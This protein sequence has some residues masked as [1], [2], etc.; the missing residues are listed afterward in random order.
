MTPSTSIPIPEF[1]R[2]VT[3][4][5]SR[6]HRHL[7]Y[8]APKVP[9]YRFAARASLAA[10]TIDEFPVALGDFPIVFSRGEH[11]L[12]FAMVGDP[13]VSHNQ[14]VDEDGTW[15][16]GT[17][18]PAVIRR[19]PFLLAKLDPESDEA[20]LCFDGDCAW[21]AGKDE[22]NLF[23]SEDGPTETTQTI[24]DFCRSFEAAVRRTRA[25]MDELREFE[26]LVD[27]RVSG[28]EARG[29]GR[30]PTV[31]PGFQMVDEERLRG[32]RAEQLRRLMLSGGQAG[33]FAHLFSLRH[34]HRLAVTPAS[35]A[36]A[37]V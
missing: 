34:L 20:S 13:N 8:D 28:D 2:F 15:R 7:A 5:I 17:Y 30:G 23:T 4:L 33:I 26:L 16:A 18:I 19:Y 21:L 27:L 29:E 32:L 36:P 35:Q 9:D 1:Y 6:L 12:P 24:L 37:V 22:G 25:F 10:L 3:P 11:P 31:L 14:F